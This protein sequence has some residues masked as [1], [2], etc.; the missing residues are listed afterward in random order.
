VS[1]PFL[2]PILHRWRE[3]PHELFGIF[4]DGE[5]WT[6]LDTGS[7][8]RRS[9]QFAALYGG[10]GVIAGDVVLI[11]MQHGIDAHA[12]FAGA[13]LIGAVPA[14]MPSPSAK[15][16][17]TLY[18]WQHREVFAH[19]RA[20]AILVYEALHDAVSE[21]AS[22]SGA[23]ILRAHRVDGVQSADLGD[24][25]GADAIGLLQHS[26]GTTGLKKGVALSYRAIHAQ[27]AAYRRALSLDAVEHPRIV[28]WLPLY[29][30]MGLISSFLLPMWAGI[31][32]LSIDPFEWARDPSLLFE[33]IETFAGTHAWV[34]NFALRH[35]V[36]SAREGITFDLRSLVALICCSEP[37]KPE[38]FDA[39]IARFS[40]SGITA[41]K[42]Q[43]CYAMAETVF[44]MTQ[45][46][47][48]APV[49]RLCVDRDR[50]Y[51]DSV[52][53]APLPGAAQVA[54]LSNGCALDGCDLRI[55]ADG[56]FVGERVVGEICV[57]APY[58]FSGYHNTPDA[59]GEAFFGKWYRTGDLGFVDQGEVFITG[60]LK[61]VI[62][63]NGRSVFAHDVEAAVARVS[64]VKP[65]RAVAF[66]RYLA[67]MGSEQL[68]VVAEAEPVGVCA[69]DVI[70]SINRAVR[71]ELGVGC[72]DVLLVAPGWLV[73]TTSGKVSRLENSAKYAAHVSG[74]G[75][76][77]G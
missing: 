11:V 32:I 8:M 70:A 1:N 46:R 5:S 51:A 35:Q 71:E 59:D 77:T 7:F 20:R 60:R 58:L 26:S 3:T 73:K 50:L 15:Q 38:A 63:L 25:P 47:I 53:E 12:A 33:A 24:L 65:G 43:S 48:G 21:A 14:F 57:H 36:K 34:P 9:L 66:G 23:T 18:W 10:S 44:A 49:R 40:A 55:L 42:L 68:I 6:P 13:M 56:G 52:A 16:D 54:L 17:A 30:D 41:D 4:H 64:G 75:D 45:S 2:G 39:F 37:N 61:D 69:A 31:P 72:N 76:G 67:Q 22:G 74:S 62:I 28:T 19:A 27:L 29:H